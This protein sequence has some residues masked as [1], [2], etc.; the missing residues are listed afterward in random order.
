M[1]WHF[2]SS[3]IWITLHY[4]T[5]TWNQISVMSISARE[6]QHFVCECIYVHAHL[7]SVFLPFIHITNSPPWKLLKKAATQPVIYNLQRKVANHF[8]S[9]V[10]PNLCVLHIIIQVFNISREWHLRVLFIAYWLSKSTE[11]NWSQ[12]LNQSQPETNS[13]HSL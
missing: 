11:L 2:S 6:M 9:F 13:D 12:N 8:K 1:F 3:G 4:S 5:E 10:Y 7:N